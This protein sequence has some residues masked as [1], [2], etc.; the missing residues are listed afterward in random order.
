MNKV[1]FCCGIL[2][3]LLG[4]C[5]C[6]PKNADDAVAA[7]QTDDPLEPMNRGIFAF[8]MALDKL[9]LKP[10]AQGYRYVVPEPARRGVG[11]FFSNLKQPLYL[12]NALLQGEGQAAGDISKRFLANTFWGF[13]GVFDVASDLEI[14]K[15]T[16]DFG[17]TLAVWGW[18][19]SSPYLVLP[20]LGPSNPRDA[21]GTGVDL[22]FTPIDWILKNEPTLLY[23]RI[24]LENWDKREKALDLLDNLE[25]SS[26]D[27]Y[28]TT[29]SMYQQN[30]RQK[31][32]ESVDRGTLETKP[33]DYE[34]D[35][36]IDEE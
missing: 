2:V 20:V 25:R 36:D 18:H 26:T 7:T 9:I 4:G 28:A 15:I 1:V 35:F 31:I 3:L 12:I 16:N 23:S 19:E 33:A 14:P 17:Q 5:A 13:L 21:V 29:R 24:A 8:N 30:R 32:A 6:P 22:V 10:V 11:N 27:F 34:F